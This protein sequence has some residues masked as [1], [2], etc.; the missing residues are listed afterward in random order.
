MHKGLRRLVS[1]VIITALGATAL[2]STG[3]DPTV[4]A[5]V[6]NGII[7]SSQSL[8]ASFLQAIISVASQQATQN[9]TNTGTTT[10]T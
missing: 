5:T 2:L 4:Q 6:E 9:T 7:T 3:C 8:F 1:L 10:T